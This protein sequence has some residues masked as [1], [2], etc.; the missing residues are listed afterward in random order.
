MYKAFTQTI[1]P[2]LPVAALVGGSAIVL[3]GGLCRH[4]GVT[5]AQL[6]KLGDGPISR[7]PCIPEAPST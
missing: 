7:E 2:Q 3:H 6:R 4:R 1:F 5:M